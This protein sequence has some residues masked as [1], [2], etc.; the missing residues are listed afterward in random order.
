ME[1]W[2]RG[3]Y[4]FGAHLEEMYAKNIE[5]AEAELVFRDAKGDVVDVPRHTHQ[6][7]LEDDV[8]T[9]TRYM[10]ERRT[11]VK[12]TRNLVRVII[13]KSRRPAEIAP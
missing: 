5:I 7:K 6:M 1:G 11:H 2:Y 10:D 12:Y 9:L 4:Y 3:A 8:M 13:Q